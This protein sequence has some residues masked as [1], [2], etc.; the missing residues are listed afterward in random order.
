M[1]LTRTSSGLL[2]HD[3]FGTDTSADYDADSTFVINSGYFRHVSAYYAVHQG[4]SSARCISATGYT[5]VATYGCYLMLT[6]S[7]S[8]DAAGGRDGYG[9]FI[10][11]GTSILR[12]LVDDGRTTI[13][14]AATTVAASTWYQARLYITGGAVYAKVGA[15]ALGDLFDVSASDSTYTSGMYGAIARPNS[16]TCRYDDL[17]LRTAHTI[18]C[19]G[20]STG[21]YLRVSDGTTAAEA[22]E[23]SGTATVDAG[24]VLFPLASVQIRTAAAGGGD[25]IA[26][27]DTG[28][29]ADMGGG[30]AFVYSADATAM[31]RNSRHFYVPSFGPVIGR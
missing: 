10:T 16:N 24:A 31:S 14:S 28:D 7:A 17:D 8:W 3:D 27:L 18:T 1:G 9:A 30:D 5:D 11:N 26:E 13:A 4:T 6:P 22:Q 2:V 19:F 15:S 12:K 20:M 23:S 21:H 25:L 29:Y